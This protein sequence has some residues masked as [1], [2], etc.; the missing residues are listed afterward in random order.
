LTDRLRELF[1]AL[2]DFSVTSPQDARYNC[3][4]WAAGEANRWWSP[5]IDSYWPPDVPMDYGLA[6]YVAA[7]DMLGYERC[8]D[9]S[10]EEGFEKVAIY[11][12]LSGYVVH[13][14]RQLHTGRWTSKL[15]GLEDIEHASPAELEGREYG[16]V[17]QYMR[18]V[19]NSPSA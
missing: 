9:G 14:A 16:D 12:P 4:A 3:I 10:L 19:V 2:N 11:E 7:F 17:V 6:A 15:G 8:A 1:P 18:R 13:M 5:D